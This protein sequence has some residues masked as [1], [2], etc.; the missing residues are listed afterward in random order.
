M[1]LTAYVRKQEQVDRLPAELGPL[2]TE[3]LV[4]ERLTAGH[5]ELHF[6]A[7][8][9]ERRYVLTRALMKLG[10]QHF[11]TRVAPPRGLVL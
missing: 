5:G 1:S 3:A 4:E 2:F 7:R 6:D 8:T 9:E 10:L 11:E